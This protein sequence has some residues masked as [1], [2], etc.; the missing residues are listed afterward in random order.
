LAGGYK[1]DYKYLSL[2]NYKKIIDSLSPDTYIINLC[3]G[4][5]EIDGRAGMCVVKHLEDT[6]RI[7]T[8]SSPKNY[9][10]KKSDIKKYNVSTPKYILVEPNRGKQVA[11]LIEDDVAHMR[12][13]FFIKPDNNGGSK[14]ITISSKVENFEAMKK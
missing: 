12:Y 14:G 7:Y 4:M 10:W 2:E 5:D 3:D 9:E 13:P 8:G 6:N 11:E 1:I